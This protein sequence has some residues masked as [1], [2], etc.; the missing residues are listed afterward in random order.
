MPTAPKTFRPK[1]A[2]VAAKVARAAKQTDPFYLSSAWRRLA[3]V[4][5]AEEPCCRE[6]EKA[7][8]AEP[9]RL[10]DHIKPRSQRPDLELVR[11]NLQGL[12]IGCHNVKTA[13]E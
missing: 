9:T 8:R 2:Q 5:K 7:G 13:K 3:A 1:H 6:C 12:C 10:I 11:E 4:V